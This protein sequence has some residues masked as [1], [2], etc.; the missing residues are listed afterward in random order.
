MSNESERHLIYGYKVY[1]PYFVEF[2][3]A[4]EDAIAQATRY[5]NLFDKDLKIVIAE[6]G[7]DDGEVYESVC[8]TIGGLFFDNGTKNVPNEHGF[9]SPEPEFD[10]D[11]PDDR[12]AFI[13][14]KYGEDK[15]RLF[16]GKEEL[17]KYKAEQER[18]RCE[19]QK[20][21]EK[22]ERAI[23]EHYLESSDDAPF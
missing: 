3:E 2:Y 22:L 19:E 4:Y 12:I 20:K 15:A 11:A 7:E 16:F 9:M 10:E 6:R 21:K 18:L 8:H 17:K 13:S 5:I 23:A 1:F 14:D